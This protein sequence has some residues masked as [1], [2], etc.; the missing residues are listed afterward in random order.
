[1]RI[2]LLAEGTRGDVQPLLV[3]ARELQR[4]GHEPVL[5][6]PPDFESL[7]AN[8][9]VAYRC[10]GPSIREFLAGKAAALVQGGA[11]FV[12]A[13]R[14]YVGE[15]VRRQFARADETRGFDLLVGAGLQFGGPSLAEVHGVPYRYIA[16]TPS[17]LV[18]R[19]HPAP[20]FSPQTW[21][22]WANRLSWWIFSGVTTALVGGQLNRE[23]RALGLAPAGNLLH[24][25][26]SERP[27]IAVD[28]ILAP[29]P[30][31]LSFD[32]DPVGFLYDDTA[33]PLPEKLESFLD[34][35]PPPVYVGFGSMTD[36]APDDTTGQLIAAV[37]RVG[38]RAVISRG[39]AELA[40]GALPE[41]VFATGPVSHA[42][43][44]PRMAAVVHH[45]GAGTTAAASRAGVPQLVVPHAVD[46]FYWAHRVQACGV[47]IASLSRRRLRSDRLADLL[48][49]LLESEHTAVRSRELGERLRAN[50]PTNLLA[51]SSLV[52]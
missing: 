13:V 7:A 47:G 50:E 42:R 29:I 45:G 10:E 30:D 27:W 26:A 11:G 40:Q 23:R 41:S 2:A 12:R 35:G 28:T 18:S 1:M 39:W 21:P 31:D 20:L 24:H 3:L 33:E 37:E 5:F 48:C 6:G 25:F 43:L 19:A 46:Q 51:R 14:G 9:G 22:G 32:V 49:A 4:G 38:C 36:Q 34:A 8:R 16:Y 15:V 52:G 44:F 17:L